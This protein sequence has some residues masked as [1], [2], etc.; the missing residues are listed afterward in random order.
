MCEDYLAFVMSQ[1]RLKDSYPY[2]KDHE[3]H[4]QKVW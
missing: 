1:Q 4:G 3:A 2:V